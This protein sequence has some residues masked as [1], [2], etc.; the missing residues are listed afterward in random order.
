MFGTAIRQMG[1]AWS[2]LSGRRFRGSHV[3]G[4]AEDLRTTLE[5]FGAPGDRAA[6]M[7]SVSDPQ[8][9]WDL[10]QRRLRRTVQQ[11]ARD[12]PYYRAWFE[13]NGVNPAAV[14]LDSLPTVAPTPK[15]ALRELPAAFVSDRARPVLATTTT[16]TTGTPTLVW[17]SQYE[18]EVMSGLNAVGLML[19]GGLRPTHVWANCVSSRSI[20]RVLMERAVPM[21]GAA[22]VQVGVVDPGTVLDRLTKPLHIPGKAARVTHL[23]AT[24]SYLAALVQEAERGGRNARDFGLEEIRSGGEILTDALRV[25]AEETFGAPV[26]DSY[27]MTE[28]VPVSGQVCSQRHL[29]IP[30]DQGHVEVLNDGGE[31]IDDPACS[32]WRRLHDHA[33]E[34]TKGV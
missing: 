5:E 29:H 23:N 7:L 16:G 6:E 26:M 4:L 21:A 22:F 8:M 19:G 17:F 2:M 10:T 3:V 30:P 28:I 32:V 13:A 25:R 1:F 31:G 20:A 33:S 34:S 18:L 11:A 27:S 15:T 9:Q 24:A 12:T 14:T